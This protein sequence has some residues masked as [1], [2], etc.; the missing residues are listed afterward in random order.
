MNKTYEQ[1]LEEKDKR[2]QGI[3]P[4][5]SLRKAQTKRLED[6]YFKTQLI[7]DEKWEQEE[8]EDYFEDRYYKQS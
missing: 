4:L 3:P 1:S 2:E 6:A 5:R 8:R 7:N